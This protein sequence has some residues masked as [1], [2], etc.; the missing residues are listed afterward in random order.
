[1]K[2]ILASASERRRELLKWLVNDFEIIVSNE[3]EVLEDG[4][5]IEKQSQ[6]LAYI[7]AKSVF[8]KTTGN[9]IVIGSDTMVYKD[10]KLYG[11]PKDNNDAFNMLKTLSNS[12]HEV[13]TSLCVL[14]QDGDEYKEYVTYDIAKMYLKEMSDEEINN[15]INNNYVL[16]KAGSYALQTKFS[17]FVKK[18]DGNFTTIVG[19]PIHKLYDIIKNYIKVA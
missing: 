9:R 14:I 7:K 1:M 16:D 5:S 12:M 11:K 4:L 15:W 6:K 19:F 10:N 17:V 8:D 13:I 3:E 18:I 2:I